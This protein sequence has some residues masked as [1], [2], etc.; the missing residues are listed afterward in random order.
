MT[1]EY[2][3]YLVEYHFDGASWLITVMAT[4]E[5]EAR[6][7]LAQ[8]ANYGE[9]RGTLVA[10]IPAGPAARPFVDLVCRFRN[11]FRRDK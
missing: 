3:E 8:A 10:K 9:I 4:N 11:F 6:T 1:P 7:R 2:R 5:R